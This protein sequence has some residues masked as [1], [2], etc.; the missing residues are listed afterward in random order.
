LAGKCGL[1]AG[2]IL[3]SLEN[4]P[5]SSYSSLLETIMHFRAG[6][7]VEVSFYRGS[8]KFNRTITLSAMTLPQVPESPQQLA[9]VLS[10]NQNKYCDEMMSLLRAISDKEASFKPG[11]NEWS[12]KEIIAHLVHSERDQQ[13]WIQNTV[14]STEPQYDNDP[15]NLM[16][17]VQATVKLYPTLPQLL[18]LLRASLKETVTLIAHLPEDLIKNK[19]VFWRLTYVCTEYGIHLRSHAEQIENNLKLARVSL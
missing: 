12:I 19:D 7:N 13:L 1:Q 6:D 11:E 8:Q 9:E 18:E 3:V 5:I 15:D 17:R 10:K 4:Q 16:A 14:Q 2:D